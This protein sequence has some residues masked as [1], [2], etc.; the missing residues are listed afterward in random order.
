M[1]SVASLAS[2]SPCVSRS[3]TSKVNNKNEE[4]WKQNMKNVRKLSTL[5]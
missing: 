1:L 3:S 2:V 4:L 5:R